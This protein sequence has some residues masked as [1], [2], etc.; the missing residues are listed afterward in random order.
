LAGGGRFFPAGGRRKRRARSDAPHRTGG[1][2]ARAER[3]GVRQSSGCLRGAFR[4][5]APEDWRSPRR[6]RVSLDACAE[7][8]HHR[9]TRFRAPVG[10]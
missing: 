9:A 1:L 3:L 5:K 6:W 8:E 2:P 4:P 7:S 10:R